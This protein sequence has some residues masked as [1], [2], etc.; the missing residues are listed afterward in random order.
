M[1]IISSLV[2]TTVDEGG[3]PRTEGWFLYELTSGY[4]GGGL[5][6]DVSSYFRR[7]ERGL[8]NPAS[9][10]GAM[11]PVINEGDLPGNPASARLQLY[12]VRATGSGL[13]DMASGVAVS[14]ARA[15]I[16]VTGY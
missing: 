2:Y 5:V 6:F 7:L 8:A 1:A 14:G 16:Y 4:L 3:A 15:T 11:I 9:G 13:L 10:T 12:G